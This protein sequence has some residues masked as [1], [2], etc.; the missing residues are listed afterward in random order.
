MELWISKLWM[1]LGTGL[2]LVLMNVKGF[3]GGG[4]TGALR[5]LIDSSKSF[6][7]MSTLGIVLA[8]LEI[9]R[10]M[11][12]FRSSVSCFGLGYQ[13]CDWA[14]FWAIIFATNFVS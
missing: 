6:P 11:L 8:T 4:G 3:G 14:I 12:H 1:V 5:E 10:H 9:F 2:T 13:T 7:V